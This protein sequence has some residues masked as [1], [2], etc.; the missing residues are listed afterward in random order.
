MSTKKRI[1]LPKVDMSHSTNNML[2]QIVAKRK[3]DEAIVSTK[4]GVVAELVSALHK[5]E[6]N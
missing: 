5:R 6:F 1:V 4:I 2:D 3:K